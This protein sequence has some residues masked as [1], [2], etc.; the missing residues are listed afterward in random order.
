MAKVDWTLSDT[1]LPA[2]MNQIGTEINQL[3]TDVDNITIPDG[4]TAQKGIVQLSNSTSGSSQTL[5]ATEKAVSDALAQAK[6]Y[7]DQG[8]LWGAL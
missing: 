2:D 7:V 4:T 3:R 1:V 6:A 5:A 8:N